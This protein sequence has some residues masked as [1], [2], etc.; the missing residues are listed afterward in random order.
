MLENSRR[1]WITPDCAAL[2]QVDQRPGPVELA[3]ELRSK[4]GK[5]SRVPVRVPL[6]GYR[7]TPSRAYSIIC[8]KDANAAYRHRSVNMHYHY[9]TTIRYIL[10]KQ[11][12]Q[13]WVSIWV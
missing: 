8:W 9:H 4:P 12:A 11:E 5:Y 3:L 2:R 7:V 6:Q 13:V 1:S 10:C